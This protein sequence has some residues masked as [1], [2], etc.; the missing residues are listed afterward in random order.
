MRIVTKLSIILILF[1][2]GVSF[3]QDLLSAESTLRKMSLH[4]RGIP[5]TAQEYEALA[6]HRSEDA[7]GKFIAEKAGEY[8]ASERHVKRMKFRLTEKFR[9][10][11]PALSSNT[12]Q[13]NIRNISV[14]QNSLND[15]FE[16]LARD[17]LSWDTL[18]N[19]KKY[20]LYPLQSEL[21]SQSFRIIS[22]FDFYRNIAPHLPGGHQGSVIDTLFRDIQTPTEPVELEFPQDDLRIAGALTTQRFLGRYTTTALNKNRRRAA[23]VFEAFLCDPMI[24]AI[25]SGADRKHEFLDSSFAENFQVTVPGVVEIK[26]LLN[27]D[28]SH[29]T[30]PQCMACHSKLDPMGQTFQGNGITIHPEPF[31]GRLYFKRSSTETV[32]LPV[33]GIGELAQ[34]ITEQPEYVECQIQWFWTQFIGKDVPLTSSKMAELKNEF[35]RVGRRTNDFIRAIVASPEFRQR[36][37]NDEPLRFGQVQSL[38]K[39]CDSCHSNEGYMPSFSVLP[40]GFS[41]TEKEQ[42]NWLIKT[43]ERLLL[44]IGHKDHMPKDHKQNW[45][46]KDFSMVVEW[47]KHGARDNDGTPLLKVENIK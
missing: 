23:A 38:L 1:Y 36:P 12:D 45:T 42:T 6:A 44:P 2:S 39:R 21:G 35:E 24:P 33:R 15:L 43:Q 16:S 34:K 25:G 22:D 7:K 32:D 8:L 14:E 47:L 46:D 13:S 26:A 27:S 3:G 37:Q 19:G 5:P 4:I 41:K 10:L 29:G 17:N 18:L 30:D 20:R 40:I 28:Q 31:S 11:T 9:L